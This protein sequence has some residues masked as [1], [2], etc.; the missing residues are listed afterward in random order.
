MKYNTEILLPNDGNQNIQ[1]LNMK[2][3]EDVI[4]I[5]LLLKA[6]EVCA[7]LMKQISITRDNAINYV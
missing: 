2:I 1:E 7:H 5:A 4:S 6:K 3:V